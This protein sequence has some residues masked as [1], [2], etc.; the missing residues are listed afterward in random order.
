MLENLT[1]MRDKNKLKRIV[2]S[3]MSSQ[4][5][6]LTSEEQQQV[7]II[8]KQFDKDNDGRLG[9][10]DVAKAFKEIYPKQSKFISDKDMLEIINKC[11]AN[12][13][14]YIDISEWHTIAISHRRILSDE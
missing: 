12:G 10:D 2:L 14:G 8:F 7:N 9:L 13:D 3:Y 1:L 4:H 6:I 5:P 11:D